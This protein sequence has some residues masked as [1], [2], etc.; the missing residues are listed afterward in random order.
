MRAWNSDGVSRRCTASCYYKNSLGEFG[1]LT[2]TKTVSAGAEGETFAS[3][4]SQTLTF[5]VV[6]PGTASCT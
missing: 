5:E 6:N 2:N 1:S 4:Q 3:L